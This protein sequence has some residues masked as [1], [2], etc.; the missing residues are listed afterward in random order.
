MVVQ[1]NNMGEPIVNNV[2][3]TKIIYN[4]PI[5]Y[6]HVISMWDNVP[7]AMKTLENFIVRLLKEETFTK[8][9]LE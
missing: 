9:F 6:W 2:V 1:L 5:D 4:L 3:I 8:S 7:N